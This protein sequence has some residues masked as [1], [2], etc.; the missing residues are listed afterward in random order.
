M[1]VF[2]NDIKECVSILEKGGL[3]LYPT[4]TIWG[5]GCDATNGNAI[6]KIY[7]LKK[8][9]DNKAFI[10]LLADEKDILKYVAQPDLKI[11]EYLKTITRPTTIIYDGAIGLADNLIPEDG[12]IAIRIT[13]DP[14]CKRLIKQFRKPIISTSANIYGYPSPLVFNDIDD[15]IK[16]GVDYIVQYRQNDLAAA[17]PSSIIRWHLDGTLTVIRS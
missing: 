11:F 10:I 2:E 3:I 9:P 6:D 17:A 1:P 5:I 13:N 14:F 7:T 12:T 8:R 4:D 15:I 16:K